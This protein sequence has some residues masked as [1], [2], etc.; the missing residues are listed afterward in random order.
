MNKIVKYG[1]LFMIAG[2]VINHLF[3]L[4]FHSIPIDK[5]IMGSDPTGYYQYLPTFF[6]QDWWKFNHL[7]WAI[8]FGETKWLSV[9]T[10]G[11]AI[12]WAPF[13]L[14]GHFFTLFLGFEAN[15]WGNVYFGF[16]LVAALFYVYAGLVFLYKFLLN[17]V[18]HASALWTTILMYIATN[19]FYYT[20][21]LGTGMSHAYSFSL[22]SVFLYF[23]HRFYRE[24]SVRHVI[25]F[26]L[27]MS[28]AVL[29]RPT[30]IIAILF[31]LLFDVESLRG[32]KERF[33]FWM[34]NYRYL[35]TVA[36]TGFVVFIPQML[37]WHEVTGKYIYYSYQDFGFSNW[38]T[39]KFGVVLFGKFNGWLTY[40]PLVLFALFG[41][42]ALLRKKAM[43]SIAILVVLICAVYINASWWV[44]TFSAALGQRAMIDFLP[45]IAIPLAW[46]LQQISLLSRKWRIFFLVILLVIVYFNVQFSFRYDPVMWWE[47]PFTWSKFFKY[48]WFG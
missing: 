46:S 42:F 32:L 6:L 40:T 8:S 29:I 18:D 28:L 15:G 2:I 21:I 11:V 47:P 44:P 20:S 14:L 13:F 22:I 39:P 7:P 9:F 25:L 16:V 5:L 31:V 1:V 38:L 35:I 48:V 37:Y 43:Q 36:V 41:L 34:K 27:P 23:V 4:V 45:F 33:L 24:P 10:C 30:N 12:L 19:L 26:A 3:R 17:Y